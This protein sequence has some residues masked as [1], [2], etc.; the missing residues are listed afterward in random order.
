[1]PRRLLACALLACCA[2][3]TFSRP[4]RAADDRATPLLWATVNICDTDDHPDTIGIRGSMP[5]TGDSDVRMYMRFNVQFQANDQS[6]RDLSNG[7][8]SGWE[9]VGRGT[10]RARQSGRSFEMQPASGSARL[11]GVVRFEWRRGGRVLRHEARVTTA[12]HR[13][14]AGADPDGYSRATCV[15]RV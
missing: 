6:W 14:S 8:A 12:G 7:G 15:I 1:M 10:Y 11:R 9:Y 4:A 13:S 2:A 3:L 5:G